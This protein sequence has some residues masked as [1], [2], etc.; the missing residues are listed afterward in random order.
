[1]WAG[2]KRSAPTLSPESQN[3]VL[4]SAVERRSFYFSAPPFLVCSMELCPLSSTPIPTPG[5]P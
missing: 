1:M 4:E 2:G 5:Y 3:S